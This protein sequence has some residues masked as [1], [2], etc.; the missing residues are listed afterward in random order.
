MLRKL[1][2]LA[3][4]DSLGN[5]TGQGSNDTFYSGSQTFFKFNIATNKIYKT[6]KP[7][8]PVILNKLLWS[9]FFVSGFTI[10]RG[11]TVWYLIISPLTTDLSN[12]FRFLSDCSV[13]PNFQFYGANPFRCNEWMTDLILLDLTQV[14]SFRS[15]AYDSVSQLLFHSMFCI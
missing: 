6:K 14:C 7:I 9:F 3:N 8:E 15:S 10:L 4:V 2:R 11:L 1:T 13:C 5:G 12:T